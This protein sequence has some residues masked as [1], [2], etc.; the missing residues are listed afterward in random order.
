MREKRRLRHSLHA[1]FE[2]VQHADDA[3]KKEGGNLRLTYATA[4]KLLYPGDEV[5]YI[6]EGRVAATKVKRIF[7]D[8]LKVSEG[9]LPFETVSEEWWL[10]KRVARETLEMRLRGESK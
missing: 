7:A 6:D 4:K 2:L 5:Y 9:F 3:G 1:V 10:T 8:S